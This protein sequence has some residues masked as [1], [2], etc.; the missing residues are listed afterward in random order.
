MKEKFQACSETEKSLSALPKSVQPFPD[1]DFAQAAL[2]R[3]QTA[4]GRKNAFSL[5]GRRRLCAALSVAICL[6]VAAAAMVSVQL[7]KRSDRYNGIDGY[8]SQLLTDF[9]FADYNMQNGAD[10]PALPASDDGTTCFRITIF[11]KSK[12][13]VF[14]TQTSTIK[15]ATVELSAA[16]DKC[17]L[18]EA[19]DAYFSDGCGTAEIN[20]VT[21][22]LSSAQKVSSLT[23][24][25]FA[26]DENRF[27]LIVRKGD[28]LDLLLSLLEEVI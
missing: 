8:E 16:L 20:G 3:R 17:E 22:E 27:F 4:I 28:S 10:F 25:R 11:K 5:R 26:V 14:L 6:L 2:S 19:Y 7:I 9:G 23:A 24:A 21:A 12:K 18:S 1:K 13:A 15:G